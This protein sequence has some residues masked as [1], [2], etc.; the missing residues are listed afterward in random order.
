MRR[1]LLS[2][3]L[4]LIQEECKNPSRRFNAWYARSEMRRE[5]G[6]ELC[7]SVHF[8][9]DYDGLYLQL[10]CALYRLQPSLGLHAEL[11]DAGSWSGPGALCG[12]GPRSQGEKRLC[13]PVHSA[14]HEPAN[15]C[16]RTHAQKHTFIPIVAFLHS[17]NCNVFL[18][19]VSTCSLIE[20]RWLQSV[21][22]NAFHPC[23][24]DP[25]RSS[26]QER[27]RAHCNGQRQEALTRIRKWLH[28]PTTERGPLENLRRSEERKSLLPPAAPPVQNSSGP[29]LHCDPLPGAGGEGGSMPFTQYEAACWLLANECGRIMNG[30]HW[31]SVWL[32]QRFGN[33]TENCGFLRNTHR[34]CPKIHFIVNSHVRWLYHFSG[35][36]SC[37]PFIL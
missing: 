26:H 18:F 29:I 12:G 32:S 2:P 28:F 34:I 17:D 16:W 6:R 15:R 5:D 25:Q 9:R 33:M 30:D 24:S 31:G 13:G 21:P 37:R 1:R 36:A 22:R 35:V 10:L 14:F 11:P 23:Q 19:R 20:G 3:I 4:R 7:S 8:Q 27:V